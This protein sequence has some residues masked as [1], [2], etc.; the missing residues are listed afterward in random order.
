MKNQIILSR[1]SIA[2]SVFRNEPIKNKM[3]DLT[4]AGRKDA[5]ANTVEY[6]LQLLIEHFL[7]VYWKINRVLKPGP[8]HI[9]NSSV[10]EISLIQISF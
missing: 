5:M 4:R 9:F 8:I 7:Q 2:Q 6:C 1:A 10:C 3:T